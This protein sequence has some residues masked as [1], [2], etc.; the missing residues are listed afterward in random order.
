MTQSTINIISTRKIAQHLKQLAFDKGVKILDYS[1]LEYEYLQSKK[2][3]DCLSSNDSPLVF[4]SQHAV[5][6]ISL[7][8]K[9]HGVELKNNQCYTIEGSTTHSAMQEGFTILG[10][11]KNSESLAYQIVEQKNNK[12]L[13]CC[14]NIKLNHLC[15]ILSENKITLNELEIYQKKIVP[16]KID[17]DYHGV[18]FFSPSQVDGFLRMN[19]IQKNIPAFCIGNTTA[20]YLKSKEHL[21]CIVSEKQTISDVVENVMRCFS[22]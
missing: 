12:V 22:F 9:K 19:T 1:F 17:F 21:V 20:D 5:I 8:L 11:A 3:I 18:M 16:I 4:T 15:K 2:I 14:S 7:L 6:S 13:F 10:K